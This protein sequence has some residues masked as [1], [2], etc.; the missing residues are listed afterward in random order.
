M[1][2]ISNI[3]LAEAIVSAMWR[4]VRLCGH[5]TY[6]MTSPHRPFTP[7]PLFKHNIQQQ[8]VVIDP[9]IAAIYVC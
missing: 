9:R 3:C 5:R 6:L 7:S 4:Y 2:A 1:A 8:S